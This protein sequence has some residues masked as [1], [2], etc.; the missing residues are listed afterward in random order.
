ML[1]RLRTLPQRLISQHW[2]SRQIYRLTRVRIRRV[3]NFLIWLFILRYR[4]DMSLAAHPERNHYADF[5]EFFTRELRE[6]VRPL[7]DE[8]GDVACP[9]DGKISQIGTIEDGRI[10]Q[11]KG[12]HF[13][14]AALLGDDDEWSAGFSGGAFATIYLSPRDYHRVHMP[15][16]GRL[17]EMRYIPGHLF[18]VSAHTVRAIPGL[19]ARNERVVSLFDTDLG[20]MAV[21]LVGAIN[22]GAIETVWHGH[23]TPPYEI[24]PRN[25]PYGEDAP[26]LARGEEMG[27]F[28]MGSTVILLFGKDR[29]N[30]QPGFAHD[31]VTKMGERLGAAVSP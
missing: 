25:W 11:A 12:H 2:S 29:V 15:Y 8:T 14:C 28:N 26:R 1:D 7:A 17:R 20:P 16:G 9:A 6:G 22:V 31:S 10:F 19:F 21:V 13:T 5:N 18:S 3:K 30:W 24:E 23:V 27:R 4:V